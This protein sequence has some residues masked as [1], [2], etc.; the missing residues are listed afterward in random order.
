MTDRL[1]P[2]STPLPVR[3]DRDPSVPGGEERRP[4]R[5]ATEAAGPP[6]SELL[7]FREPSEHEGTGQNRS[8]VAGADATPAAVRRPR[9]QRLI[10]VAGAKG[11]V[12]KTIF[13]ANLALY[14]ATIGRKVVVVDADA[15]GA[16][17]HTCLGVDRVLPSVVAPMGSWEVRNGL[18]LVETP[19]PGLSL[20]HG[21]V[22]EPVHGQAT[23]TNRARL[24]SHLRE[25]DAE[26][27]VVDVGAGTQDAVID[28]WLSA[29]LSVFLTVPEPTAID[30]TYRF[31]RTAF[32][33][34]LK[35][36]AKDRA[37]RAR[38]VSRLRD[39]GNAPAPLDLA[40][41]LEAAGDPLSDL[42][43]ETIDG[44][45]FRLVLNQCR[46]RADLE[47][48]DAMRS[49]VRRRFGIDIDYLGYIDYD[50]TVWSS[51]RQRRPLLVESPGTRA[52]KSIEKIARRL[53]AI[54]SGSRTSGRERNVPTESHHDILEVDRGATDEEIR[55]AFKRT[56]EIY[57]SDSL[58]CYG[59]FD[60]P[61]LEAL[62]ARLEEAYDVLLDPAR[63]RPYELSVFPLAPTYKIGEASAVDVDAPVV[64]A[65]MITPETEFTGALLR[66]VRESIGVE[67]REI[68]QRTKIGTMYLNAIEEDD[69]KNLP[70]L[71]YVRGF[72]V[73]VAKCLALDPAQVSRTYIR[74]YKRYLDE[75]DKA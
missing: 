55:R 74:R 57:A 72:L 33:R 3:D 27:V 17:L 51:I 21:G 4:G 11:G 7:L 35:R 14:L 71:V 40:R 62:R 19:V 53:V 56:K 58:C 43:R 66:A 54:D 32:A 46:L 13:T 18:A 22:D 6:S 38:L 47:I 50:D 67:V 68:A 49:A 23:R 8:A 25:L 75:R 41:R 60:A 73:E 70:A 52:S 28:T 42:V 26:Y 10:A 20:L 9:P 59:L 37:T 24:L 65:P 16:N 61:A 44:F 36:A 15:E 48:G 5:A 30:G 2:E 64:P 1:P 69:F 39:Q 45:S 31:I 12:G 63:R 34:H 29:D